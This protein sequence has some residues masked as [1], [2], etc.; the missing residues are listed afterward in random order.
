MQRFFYFRPMWNWIGFLVRTMFWPLRQISHFLLPLSVYDGLS[1]DSTERVSKQFTSYLKTNLLDNNNNNHDDNINNNDVCQLFSTKSYSTLISEAS[2]SD[3]LI[4]VYLHSPYHRLGDHICRRLLGSPSMVRF[5]NENKERVMPLG[6]FITTAQGASLSYS[7]SVSSFPVLALLQ[8]VKS[9]IASS[10]TN[11]TSSGDTTTTTAATAASPGPAKLIFK[12]EGPTLMKISAS[13]LTALVAATFQK[14]ERAVL[15]AATK[16]YER[17][18]AAE[19][20][21][22]Q[23]EEF[24]ETLR[25]DQERERE[26]TKARLEAEQEEKRKVEEEKRK[27]TDELDRLDRARSLMKEEP[28]KGTPGT[29]RI[30]FRLSNGKQL[31]RRFGGDETIATLKAF[32]ILHFANETTTNSNDEYCVKRVGLSTNFPTRTYN[33][34]DDKT[35]TECDLCPQALLMVQ[36]LDA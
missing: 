15:E 28:A 16:R 4:M 10:N 5:L 24:Q 33:S 35:L 32:L 30:R 8:P 1:L 20:R 12:A 7:L 18:Q 17:E 21:R 13:Q 23:D 2:T 19:L 3:A 9:S 22:Q 6:S 26:R 27:V 14:H 11:S 36:D 25:Q 29:A 31:D 34:D